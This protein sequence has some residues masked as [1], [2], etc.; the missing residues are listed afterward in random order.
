MKRGRIAKFVAACLFLLSLSFA[1]SAAKV[2][3]VQTFSKIMNKSIRAVVI[4]PNHY[5]KK[6]AYPV[7]YLLHGFAGNCT[8]WIKKVPSITHLSDSYHA[9]IVCPDG[10]FAGWYINSPVNKDW[11]YD[12]YVSKELVTYIDENYATIKNRTGRAITGLSMGGHGALSLAIRHQDVYGA[13]GSMSGGVDL[14]PFATSFGINQILGK[15]EDNPQVWADHSVVGMVNNLKPNVLKITFDCGVDDFFF[16]VN[17]QLHDLLLKAKIPHDYTVR[18]GSHTWEY[19][20]N[21]INYHMVFFD[22]F[23]KHANQ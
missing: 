20:E 11:Q 14:R 10:G 5:K 7:V 17:N 4:L 13:A 12:T 18:P 9:I 16:S 8:D 2:D 23:F 19:W 1:A 15:Y 6:E 3:T 21:S 22:R